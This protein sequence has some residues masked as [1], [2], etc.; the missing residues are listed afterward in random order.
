MDRRGGTPTPASEGSSS[1]A[2][3][4]PLSMA[5]GE[6]ALTDDD[7]PCRDH[8]GSGQRRCYSRS[9]GLGARCDRGVW[10]RHGDRVRPEGTRSWRRHQSLPGEEKETKCMNLLY[11][12]RKKKN[13][14]TKNPKDKI[15]SL[16]P[17]LSFFF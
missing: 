11:Y 1:R 9:W 14:K 10:G 5:L 7:D 17:Y 12:L 4:L 8:R 6:V 15:C 3:G 2:D 13:I 16:S